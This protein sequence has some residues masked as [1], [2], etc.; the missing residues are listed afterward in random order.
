MRNAGGLASRW[1][2]S[3]G[4]GSSMPHRKSGGIRPGDCVMAVVPAL[5]IHRVW[6]LRGMFLQVHDHKKKTFFCLH[7]ATCL[8]CHVQGARRVGEWRSRGLRPVLSPRLPRHPVGWMVDVWMQSAWL[9]TGQSN[10]QLASV[11]PCLCT[12]VNFRGVPNVPVQRAP[13]QRPELGPTPLTRLAKHIFSVQP[14]RS[15]T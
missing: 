10:Y 4:G 6:R 14:Q 7:R 9:C 1:V 3:A 11:V 15:P 2:A 5:G 12:F 13:C 8:H